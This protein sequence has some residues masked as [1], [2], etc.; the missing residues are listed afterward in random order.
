MEDGTVLVPVQD[1]STFL[2]QYFKK[3]NNIKTCHHFNFTKDRTAVKLQQY[4]DTEPT[5][6]KLL[7]VD[8]NALCD[9]AP[10]EIKPKG[11]DIKRQW[12][13]Y[14]AIREFVASK[15]Q[16]LV[17]PL[18]EAPVPTVSS[19]VESEMMRVTLHHHYNGNMLGVDVVVVVHQRSEWTQLW[20]TDCW[21]STRTC[22]QRTVVVLVNM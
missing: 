15:K 5:Y 7:K 10:A 11:L 6:Q 20:W 18:P 3:V 9:G 19:D 2:D 22:K 13:L 17:C 4:S 14:N 16:D 21:D 12:Y 8:A 1:W